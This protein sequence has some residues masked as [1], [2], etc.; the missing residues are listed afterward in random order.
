MTPPDAAAIA[1]RLREFLAAHREGL[2][3][4]TRTLIGF[5]TVSGG[6]PQQESR[7]REQLPAA[8]EW[9][10]SL[11]DRMGFEFRQWDHRVAEIQW[12]PDP[13]APEGTRP[14]LGIASHIDVVTPAGNWKYGPFNATIGEDGILYGRGIQDDKGPLVQSLYGLWAVK[15]SGIRPNCDVRV[16]IGT[17]EETGVWTDM[18][19]YLSVRPAPDFSFTPDADFPVIT[20]EK[21]MCNLVFEAS[22]P[23][24]APDPETQME[25][26]EFDGG[27][28]SNI[29]PQLAEVRL[30][31]P[32]EAKHAVMKELVRETT[33]FTVEN[34]GS[35]ITLVPSEDRSTEAAGYYE[36][37]VSFLGKAAHSST[38]DA[39]YNA[40][41]DAVK[42]FA[43]METLPPAVRA[44][45][46]FL[47]I[48]SASSDGSALGVES[49]HEFVGATT[50]PLTLV[51]ITQ[52]GARAVLNVRP[53]MGMSAETVKQKGCELAAAFAEVS[54]LDIKVSHQGTLHDAIYLDPQRPGVGAFLDGL[55]TAFSTVTGQPGKCVAIGGT[56]YA[57]A[58]PNCCAFG[59]VLPGVDEELA[60][61]ADERFAVTS[62]ERNALIYGLAVALMA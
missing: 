28:R 7:L 9:L 41:A 59:P 44:F 46:Q 8:F 25:F 32:L 21:G 45:V 50:A 26:V 60:H 1:A 48:L 36:A 18:E 16:I 13:A 17:Q 3:E 35:N 39:G 22:W 54:G 62:I 56:T 33:R 49:T 53:T 37:L 14:V 52:T 43:D 24:V 42:F 29:I 2:L 10:R 12:R 38:P 57:K 47:S 20:G 19:H 15:Q 5:E 51:K 4:D 30:R 58:L 6:T 23:R 31:F 27:Q 61:Q 11:A 34:S 55:L 40:I